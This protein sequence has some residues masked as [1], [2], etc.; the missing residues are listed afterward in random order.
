M[1][2]RHLER[3]AKLDL[4]GID[5]S[6]AKEIGLTPA[7]RD[8]LTYFADIEGQT[9]FYLIEVLK[10]RAA[11]DPDTLAFATIWN[12]EEYFHSHAITRLLTECGHPLSADRAIKVR[13]NA[14]LQA[15][16]EDLA[17]RALARLFPRSFV[18]LWM[19]WGAS[20]EALTLRGYE[21]LASTTAN[22]AL[23][24]ICERIA[25]QE[26]RHFAWY[27]HAAREHLGKSR[28]AQRLVRF[29]F[30]RFWSPVGAGVKSDAQVM[31]LIAGLFPKG[32]LEAVAR[33]I[34][35]RMSKLPGMSGFCVVRNWVKK[36]SSKL[37]ASPGALSLPAG[38][39]GRP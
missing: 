26:R 29:V 15:K 9:V 10:L 14:Q 13:A 4:S 39:W 3:S 16:L 11:Q 25:K 12:Y 24:T 21:Q 20:Q 7:E 18:A 33:D 6:Q 17:Q 19:A 30:D 27:Y 1:I 28:F 32:A 2:E 8:A 31:Q 5:W 34:D 23:R 36:L 22:P 35:H 38:E 37:A